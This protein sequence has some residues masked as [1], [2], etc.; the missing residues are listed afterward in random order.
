MSLAKR[1]Q[2]VT[3]SLT[4]AIEAK[5]KKLK[6][7]GIDI[8]SFSA[9]EPDC[10]TPDTIKQAAIQALQKGVT[11][12]TPASGTLELRK[13]ISEKL[14]QENQLNYSPEQIVELIFLS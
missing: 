3:P 2:N 10:D 8:I 1:I 5:A 7:D 4:L 13:A 9:G 11:K 6:Q 14:A 12:Y